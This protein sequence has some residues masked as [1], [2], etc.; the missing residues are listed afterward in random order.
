MSAPGSRATSD[1]SPGALQRTAAWSVHA[2]TAS[3]AAVGLFA[4]LATSRGEFSAAALWMLVALAIDGVDGTL[5]RRLRVAALTPGIDGRRLDDIV[6][7]LNYV[8]VP[9]FFLVEA[10]CVDH[11]GW[12]ALPVLAS[13]YGFSRSDA[14]TADHFFL[15]FPSYWNVFA[16]YAWQL[17][18]SA[19][20]TQAWIVGLA[21][22][23]FV[24]LK[25]VY[26]SQMTTFGRV[27]NGG[28]AL[29]TALM[30]LAIG[31]PGIFGSVPILWISLIYPIWYVGISMWLGGLRRAKT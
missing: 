2:L 29:W 30:A 13:A 25:F 17:D 3:G 11:M 4:L 23:V 9:A 16:I 14:K 28:A 19:M 22:A 21:V 27:T 31:V 6:D 12:A 26:P 24:P 18:V 5:A 10:G 20:A 15:G 8:V 1:G 7:Y